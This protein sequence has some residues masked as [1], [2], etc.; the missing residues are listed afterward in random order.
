MT[1]DDPMDLCFDLTAPTKI[2]LTFSTI[3]EAPVSCTPV[4]KTNLFAVYTSLFTINHKN[5]PF[6]I[7]CILQNILF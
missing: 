5:L 1:Q 3:P 2:H 6:Q 7:M 4:I